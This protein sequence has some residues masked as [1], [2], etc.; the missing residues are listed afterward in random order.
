MDGLLKDGQKGQHAT[1]VSWRAH[2]LSLIAAT[3][4][5]KA[6]QVAVVA[7]TVGWTAGQLAIDNA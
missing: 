4:S 2:N 1:A 6:R 3:V 7:A 5:L